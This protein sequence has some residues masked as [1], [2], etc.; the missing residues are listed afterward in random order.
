[1]P[2]T[3][4]VCQKGGAFSVTR[5][6][7]THLHTIRLLE[8]YGWLQSEHNLFLCGAARVLSVPDSHIVKWESKQLPALRVAQG[9][10][11]HSADKGHILQLNPFK[12]EHLT[13]IFACC[14]QGIT[15]TKAQ[16][17]FKASSLLEGFGRKRCKAHF[18]AQPCRYFKY[19]SLL[20]CNKSTLYCISKFIIYSPH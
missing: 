1:M 10:S 2:Y 6:C 5:K 3:I 15:V 17:V 9:K 8:E 4:I 12:E 7:Y 11:H 14:E 18:K 20:A 19:W 13:W 16:V